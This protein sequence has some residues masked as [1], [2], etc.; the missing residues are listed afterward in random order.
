MLL[1]FVCSLLLL[2]GNL[3]AAAAAASAVAGVPPTTS[4]P[5]YDKAVQLSRAA[6]A[7]AAPAGVLLHPFLQ[8]HRADGIVESIDQTYS[9]GGKVGYILYAGGKRFLLDLEKDALLG[10]AE[11]LLQGKGHCYYRGTVDGSAQSLAVFNLCGG[12]DGYFAVKHARYSLKP[13]LRGKVGEEEPSRERIYGDGSARVLHFFLRDHFSFE[14]LPWRPSCETRGSARP[15]LLDQKRL[16]QVQETEVPT[17][18]ALASDRFSPQAGSRSRRRRSIS[19]A[20]QVELLLVADESMATKYSKGLHHYL[21]T[22]ATIASRLYGHASI[23]NHIRLAVVKV[24]VLGDKEK[25]LEVNKNAATTL[26]NFCK[27]QH[28]HNQLDDEHEEHYDAAIL[29]TREVG[30]GG[31]GGGPWLRGLIHAPALQSNTGAVPSTFRFIL[32]LLSRCV[33]CYCPIGAIPGSMDLIIPLLSFMLL[34]DCR[35]KCR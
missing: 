13:L 2:A 32:L 28:Q 19:R 33:G 4:A 29:F 26:K 9:G 8:E 17:G 7:A 1:K 21:L 27:W 18:A 30:L 22:L 15:P 3:H 11:Q 16:A 5:A 25:G 6:A 20:R 31:G 10:S 24:V 12:L 35:W 23:E 14:T 34:F